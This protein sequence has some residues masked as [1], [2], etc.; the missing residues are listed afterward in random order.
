M[1]A[2]CHPSASAAIFALPTPTQENLW[3][4]VNLPKPTYTPSPLPAPTD[5]PV[6]EAPAPDGDVM[7]D[8]KPGE[9]K[10]IEE[11]MRNAG[12]NEGS[13]GAAASPQ[14]GAV[15]SIEELMRQADEGESDSAAANPAPAR[16]RGTSGR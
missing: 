15:K 2:Y 9:V 4:Y 6:P 11:L 12:E 13:G 10:S 14:P 3:A 7:S 1:T 16:S 5:T 8:A